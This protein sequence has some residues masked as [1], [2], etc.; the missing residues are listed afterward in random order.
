MTGED[1]AIFFSKFREERLT[2][3]IR[4]REITIQDFQKLKLL[5]IE[6]EDGTQVPSTLAGS[7]N[8]AIEKALK[9]EWEK[10][11]HQK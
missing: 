5:T 9:E 2:E 3:M 11:L 8:L 7:S 10:Y 4:N 6:L 1:F